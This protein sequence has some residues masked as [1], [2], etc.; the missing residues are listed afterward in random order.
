MTRGPWN[1]IQGVF[2]P[3]VAVWL[4]GTGEFNM[5]P[6]DLAKVGTKVEL[7]VSCPG[8]GPLMEEGWHPG[9]RVDG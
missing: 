8:A 1:I 5:Q 7:V 2:L 9:T 3:A 4:I 6:L